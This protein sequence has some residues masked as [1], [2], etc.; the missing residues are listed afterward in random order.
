MQQIKLSHLGCRIDDIADYIYLT[1]KG[2][3]GIVLDIPL[4]A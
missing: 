2:W 1:H 4:F 3:K